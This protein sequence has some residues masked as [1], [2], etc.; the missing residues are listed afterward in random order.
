MWRCLDQWR[1]ETMCV[2]AREDKSWPVPRVA[3]L[4]LPEKSETTL[5]KHE[6]AR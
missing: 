6:M 4:S 1:V 3:Q 2:A 5:T